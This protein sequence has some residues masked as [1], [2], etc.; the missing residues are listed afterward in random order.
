MGG[1]SPPT[2]AVG[3]NLRRG[4]ESRKSP[5][6]EPTLG[7]AAV[8]SDSCQRLRPAALT[9]RVLDPNPKRPL[10]AAQAE[11]SLGETVGAE[12][13][14]ERPGHRAGTDGVR[15]DGAY[16]R[17]VPVQAL[18]MRSAKSGARQDVR[19]HDVDGGEEDD[20]GPCLRR[21]APSARHHSVP[22][23]R[24]PWPA[25][26]RTG[27]PSCET[28]KGL[29]IRPILQ[30]TCCVRCRSGQQIPIESW[31]GACLDSLVR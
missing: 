14:L 22:P 3:R 11:P 19:P 18:A 24:P 21:G 26:G 16:G 17:R 15:R 4:H 23:R 9:A 12:P 5:H 1:T 2:A 20:V 7:P 8:A 25:Q 29:N 28:S 27:A 31:L 13:G 10:D 30:H 6:Q